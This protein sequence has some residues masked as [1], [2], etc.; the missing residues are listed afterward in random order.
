MAHRLVEYLYAAGYSPILLDGDTV[1]DLLPD[2]LGYD[3]ESRFQMACFNSRLCR[4]LA[5]QGCSV[6]CPTI[7]MFQAVQ[8]WNRKNIPG[9][10]EIFLDAPLEVLRE[11]DPKGIYAGFD[12]QEFINVVGLDIVAEPPENPDLKINISAY[13]GVDTTWLKI[14]QFLDSHFEK[15][16]QL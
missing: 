15:R 12:R 14:A 6:I 7:S 9:Y 8:R 1:R 16:D 11:R 10:I 5:L 2:P 4:L 13:A 3:E